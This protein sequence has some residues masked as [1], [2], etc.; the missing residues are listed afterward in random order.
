MTDLPARAV[1]LAVATVGAETDVVA[2]A[3]TVARYHGLGTVDQRVAVIIGRTAAL[4]HVV[5][6]AT[7][8]ALPACSATFAWIC[9][10][11]TNVYI[12]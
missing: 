4:G 11:D 3:R 5:G 6:H 1:V 10:S 9:K 8:G 7:A 12:G 2:L